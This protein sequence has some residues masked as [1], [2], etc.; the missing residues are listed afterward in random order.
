MTQDIKMNQLKEVGVRVG[1]HDNTLQIN[2]WKLA[3]AEKIVLGPMQ[4]TAF[5]KKR[6]EMLPQWNQCWF[7]Q[8]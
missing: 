3:L 8:T 1:V 5:L 6:K 7:V 4:E 2:P